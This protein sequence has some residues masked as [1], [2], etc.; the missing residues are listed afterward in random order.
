[1]PL[2]P[3]HPPLPADLPSRPL[4]NGES[5]SLQYRLLVFGDR[6]VEVVPLA[7]QRWTIGRAE[8]NDICLRDPTV[9]RRHL[10]LERSADDFFVRDVGSSNAMLLDGRPIREGLLRPGQTL[11]AGTT[12]LTLEARSP[13]VRVVMD[14][15]QTF[16]R[17]RE[18]LDPEGLS[19]QDASNAETLLVAGLL[20]RLSRPE[21][22][23]ESTSELAQ[24]LLE[25]TLDL[26]D[27]QRGVL[28]RLTEDGME[29]LASVDRSEMPQPLHLPEHLVREA[30][31]L[32]EPHI[33]VAQAGDES[34]HRLLI[35]LG[36]T[37]S[38]LLVLDAPRPGAVAGQRLL[39]LA[40]SLGA[41]VQ[42]RFQEGA[43]RLALREE[44]A[45]LRFQGSAAHNAVL[46][47]G[48]LHETRQQLR[49][50]ANQDIPVLLSGEEGSEHEDLARYLHAESLRGRGP[51]VSFHPVF[52]PPAT[53]DGEL[54]GSGPEH[55]G[56]LQRSHGGTL[57]IDRIEH[58][59]AAVQE[60]LFLTLQSRRLLLGG[61]S[62][63]VDVRLVAATTVAGLAKEAH[64]PYRPLVDLLNRCT[65]AIP[66][67]RSDARDVLVLAEVFLSQ[68]GPG[69]NGA[70][71]LLSERAKRVL[72][73]YRWPG[74]VRQLRLVL[75][76]AA[77]RAGLQPISPRHLEPELAT[78]AE[79]EDGDVLR[80]LEAVERDHIRD[81]LLRVGG[82]RARAAQVL[83]I[84]A[85]TLYEKIKKYAIDA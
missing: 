36:A 34:A 30:R 55:P 75:E 47:C 14:K 78:L 63:P 68:L 27:R 22:D 2:R 84:A 31:S 24:H 71:R 72:T 64:E 16:V 3:D 32:K 12:R 18:V 43:A 62:L 80:S 28:G 7:G 44:V 39:R 26:T 52:V 46:A 51:L 5:R 20:D 65:V 74:N 49:R 4:G 54:F 50:V 17:S 38:M 60:R 79:S 66:P 13:S 69:P 53:I 58:L 15:T 21:Q 9:S 59:P 42:T 25:L 10:V 48:R 77:A 37:P 29:P 82:N 70:P 83:G 35:P 11:L 45:R 61:M 41:M 33:I 56:A 23:L 1:M 6:A 73:D 85:S 8:D 40:R 19:D 67:L 76:A 81:V 57:F